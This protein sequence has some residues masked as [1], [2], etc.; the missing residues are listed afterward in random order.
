MANEELH[1]LDATTALR[2]FTKRELSPVELMRAVIARAEVTEPRIN[3]FSHTFF[4]GASVRELALA[5][6]LP[7]AKT[8]P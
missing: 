5:D 3:A 6:L 8:S 2:L 1:R 7:Q 4:G